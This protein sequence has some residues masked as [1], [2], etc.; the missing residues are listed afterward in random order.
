MLREYSTAYFSK[1]WTNVYTGL[2]MWN[3]V[4]LVKVENV[5]IFLITDF[6]ATSFDIDKLMSIKNVFGFFNVQGSA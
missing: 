5:E 3:F 1:K 4:Y 6:S 2:C